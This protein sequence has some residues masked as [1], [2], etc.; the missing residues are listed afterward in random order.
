MNRNIKNIRDA[1]ETIYKLYIELALQ[2]SLLF[3]NTLIYIIE[4]FNTSK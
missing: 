3:I 4:I 1:A 2:Q